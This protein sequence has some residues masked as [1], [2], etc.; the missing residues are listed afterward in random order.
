MSPGRTRAWTT[1][2][3]AVEVGGDGKGTDLVVEGEAV[4]R[5]GLHGRG[6]LPERF[7]EM[8]VHAAWS[9]VSDAARVAATVVR[10]A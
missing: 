8:A 3:S 2:L 7:V 4:A 1:T 9:A 5:L 10:P 6:A